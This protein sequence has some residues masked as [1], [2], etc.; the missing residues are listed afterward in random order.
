MRAELTPE[1]CNHGN[2]RPTPAASPLQVPPRLAQVRGLDSDDALV[3]RRPG[4]VLE[5]RPHLTAHTLVPL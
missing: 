1:Y 2:Q 3:E 4:R 5:G